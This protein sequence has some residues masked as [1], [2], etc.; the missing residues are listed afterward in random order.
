VA[1]PPPKYDDEDWV[2]EE[3]EDRIGALCV[4]SVG[5]ATFEALF[6]PSGS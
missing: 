2:R 6:G 3:G 1:K 5:L 4:G